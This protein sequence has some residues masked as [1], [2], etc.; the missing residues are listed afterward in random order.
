M[1]MMLSSVSYLTLIAVSMETKYV[2]LTV[3][4]FWK[5]MEEPAWIDIARV[6]VAAAAWRPKPS[7]HRDCQPPTD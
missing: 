1:F 2:L 5:L 4:G 6:S 3:M 7:V